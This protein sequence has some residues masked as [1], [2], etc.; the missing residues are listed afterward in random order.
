MWLHRNHALDETPAIDFLSGNQLREAI[1]REYRIG[2]VDTLPPVYS[3]Y[4]S[5]NA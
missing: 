3:P 5:D 1:L 2:L 4:F